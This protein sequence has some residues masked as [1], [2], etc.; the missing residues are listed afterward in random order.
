MH[1]AETDHR[2]S[3]ADVAN[4]RTAHPGVPVHVY[5]AEHGF[6]NWHRPA[7]YH[8]ASARL[9]LDRTLALLASMRSDSAG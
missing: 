8:G 9:A 1:F 7:G 2:V 5:P 4:F 6:N 3:A